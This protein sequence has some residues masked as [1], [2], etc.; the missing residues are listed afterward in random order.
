MEDVSDTNVTLEAVV[1]PPSVGV[2]LIE[3]VQIGT[4]GDG[5]IFRSN[6]QLTVQPDTPRVWWWHLESN[7]AL[8]LSEILTLVDASAMTVDSTFFLAD[9]FP[10]PY[11]LSAYFPGNYWG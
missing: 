11:Y 10:T 2:L 8:M 5:S 1:R 7:P 9:F 3:L 6:S 4:L